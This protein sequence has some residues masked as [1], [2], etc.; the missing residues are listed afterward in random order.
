MDVLDEHV[1]A[2]DEREA[3]DHEQELRREVDYRE[4]DRELCGLLHA[5]DVECDEHGDHDHAAGD[6]PRVL[7]ERLPE[8][9]EVVR[10]EERRDA[11]RDD[12][13][14]HLR[15]AG[16]EAHELV[17]GMAR[18]A[19]GAARLGEAR[20]AFGVGGSGGGEHDARDDEDERRQTERVDGGQAQC[21]VDRGADVAVGGGEEGGGAEH[22]L[23]L[24][25]TPAAASRHGGEAYSGECRLVDRGAVGSRAVDHRPA[26]LISERLHDETPAARNALPDRHAEA[27]ALPR[28][29]G[30]GRRPGSDQQPHPLVRSKPDADHDRRL[31]RDDPELRR[32]ARGRQARLEQHAEGDQ[33]HQ[34]SHELMV[35]ERGRGRLGPAPPSRLVAVLPTE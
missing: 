10:D 25:L 27:S 14:Q 6:V 32:G 18:E 5:Y 33:E 17:E 30:S 7:A 19:R 13:H 21:V 35:P 20:R 15:P 29:H 3:D 8:D 9:R 1:G 34:T 31:G 2:E 4:R 24:D 11:D 12:I 23:H 28:T 22:P 26:P 16:G